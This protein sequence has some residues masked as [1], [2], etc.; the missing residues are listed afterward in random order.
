VTGTRSRATLPVALSLRTRPGQP[1]RVL[2]LGAHADDI[3]IGCGGTLL[4]L[5]AARRKVE[6]HWVVFSGGDGPRE[7]EARESA[8]RFLARAKSHSIT[9]LAFRDGYFPH[10]GAPIKDTF[11]A[12]KVGP[13][14]DVVFTHSRQD[15]HQDHRVISDLTWN[16]FRSHLVLEYEVPKYD[17]DLGAPNLFV[18][19]AKAVARA[20]IRHLLS[21]FPSQRRK[22]WFTAATFEAMLRLRGIES[23]AGEGMAEAFHVRKATLSFESGG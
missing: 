13:S 23:G 8:T 3:E 18:P 14:P 20:K 5:L 17:G 12:L 1:L 2:C 9:V 10:S 6:C 11:E 7:A 21:A 15:R 22:R 16:T 19:V 4:T